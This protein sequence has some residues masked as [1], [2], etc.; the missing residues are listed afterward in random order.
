MNH[1]SLLYLGGSSCRRT[2]APTNRR[3]LLVAPRRSSRQLA[4]GVTL[5]RQSGRL[6]PA[7]SSADAGCCDEN[8]RGPGFAA[9]HLVDE[10]PLLHLLELVADQL[11][12]PVDPRCTAPLGSGQVQHFAP[13]GQPG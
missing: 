11:G 13:V 2:S 8:P 9:R 1:T 6:G 3:L 10:E 7:T 4:F 5:A 12:V